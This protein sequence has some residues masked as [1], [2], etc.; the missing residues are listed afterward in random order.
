[1]TILNEDSLA[2]MMSGGKRDPF[3]T[4]RAF[5]QKLAMQGTDTSPVQSPWQGVGRLA[6]ALAGVYGTYRADADEKQAKDDLATK[7]ADAGKLTDP[8]A[9]LAAYSAI[10]PEI[11]LKYSA[12]SAAEEIKQAGA[13]DE[14]R[15]TAEAMRR[16]YGVP[17]GGTQQAGGAANVIGG[18]EAG[19][20]YDAVGPVANAQGHRAW[21]KFQVLEPN[22]GP[23]TKEV[24]GREMTPQEFL[25][26][27]K[28]QDAVFNT[29]FG[30]Y[31]QKYG[32]EGAARAWF[33]GEGGMNNPNA[34]DVL[35]TTVAGYGQRFTAGMNGQGGTPQQAVLRGP[36]GVP[37]P[38]GTY[39][40][41]TSQVQLA[42]GQ[43][44]RP[45][46]PNP[47]VVNGPTMLAQGDATR[48]TADASGTPLPP[49]MPQRAPEIGRPDADPALV[50]RLADMVASRKMTIAEAD[51]QIND[52]I[53]RRWTFAQTQ[54]SEDR[55]QQLAIQTEDRKQQG[56]LDRAGSEAFIKGTADRYVKDVRPKAENAISEING[57]HQI[58]QLLDAGA[59]TG[60]GADARVFTA[61]LGE[62]LGIPSEQAANT[63]VLQSALAARVISGMGGSLG[64]G[65]S[66]ADRDFVE[67]A[68][69]GQITMTEPAL[70]RL[71]DI[72][73]RQSRMAVDA[74]GKEVA[75]LSA[76][77]GLSTMGK[78]FFTL[79]PV[80]DYATWR[81]A[82]PLAPVM[83]PAAGAPR[84]PATPSSSG[85]T[86][87]QIDAEI[88]RRRGGR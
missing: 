48:P 61:K 49:T 33:A 40:P 88:A 35:G 32:P 56:A 15:Q 87:D 58:R 21:G 55:R 64:A 60:T 18:M 53:N 24:L 43:S 1:M 8:V 9:K 26:D 2:Y 70:R 16:G 65:F 38:I 3:S 23:W 79:P 51:K 74:H 67:R 34:K 11:G 66:N 28:A 41:G 20:R 84:N 82:N 59:I 83:P 63:Q 7:I 5:A 80:Q 25:A 50:G 85:L 75:R 72:G 6:Q 12:A 73:E 76:V 36:P 77:P 19:G 39:T 68:K 86:L 45:P 31:Q 47:G 10:N 71:I 46:A 62:L 57:I 44:G 52:D 17:T 22:I 30:Q 69:G 14:A 81:E 78:D 29:K 4:R 27:Q 42:Q 54:A 13:R 37:T